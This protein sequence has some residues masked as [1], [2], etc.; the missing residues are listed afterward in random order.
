MKPMQF[1]SMGMLSLACSASWA[2][3][4]GALYHD[5]LKV[6]YTSAYAYAVPDLFDK[7]KQAVVIVMGDR[8]IDAAT[9]DAAADRDKAFGDFMGNSLR[10]GSSVQITLGPDKDGNVRVEQVNT[11]ESTNGKFSSSS[12]STMESSYKLDLKRND[13]KR[14][15][16]TYLST[17]ESDKTEAHGKFFDLHFALDVA[18]GPAFGPGLPP[19]G[20]DP[21]KAYDAYADALSHA[22]FHFDPDRYQEF[23]NTLSDGRIK[24]LNK[25]AASAGKGKS[26]DALL[27]EMKDMESRVPSSRRF[28]RGRVNGDVA[29]VE[30]A[31][32]GHNTDGTE[33]A[34]AV[35][36]ITATMK[37]EKGV[38]Y[39]DSDGQPAAEG[40]PK[41]AAQG[42]AK[43]KSS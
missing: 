22:D 12:G 43:A 39:F 31:G 17:H 33:I 3:G 38:W 14:V 40:K 15:E 5:G 7:S 34:G 37:R 25:I 1:V 23:V 16:G 2:D 36:S 41:P 9:F 18:S 29:T 13:G 10:D 24:A 19:D 28:V 26:Q 27:V 4:G 11:R 8:P 20:G 30:V 42:K 6:T 21:Y 35:I 32:K